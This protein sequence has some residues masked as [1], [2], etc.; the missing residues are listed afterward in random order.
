MRIVR[1]CHTYIVRQVFGCSN[2][3]DVPRI[4]YMT[5][6]AYNDRRHSMNV[7]AMEIALKRENDPH[8]SNQKAKFYFNFV[9]IYSC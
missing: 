4:E 3:V 7:E 8:R 5:R 1:I 2:T 6:M 9:Y